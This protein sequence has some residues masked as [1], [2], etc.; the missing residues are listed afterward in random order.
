MSVDDVDKWLDCLFYRKKRRS[1]T[2]ALSYVDIY[3]D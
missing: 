3:G 1:L 2:K